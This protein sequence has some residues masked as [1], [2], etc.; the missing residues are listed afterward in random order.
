MKITYNKN[1]LYTTIDLDEHEKK[2]LWYKIKINEMEELLSCASF[3]L[4][5][6][7]YFDLER[8]RSEVDPDYYCTDEKSPLDKRCDT[9]LEHYLADLQAC[10]VG[11]CTCVACSC[12]KCQA[13]VLLGI[14]TMPGLGKHSARKIDGAFGKDNEKT[15]EE[16]IDSLANYQI[17]PEDF[18]GEAWKKLGGYE[19]YV[20][21][22]TAE[23]KHAHDWLV[24]YKNE[25]FN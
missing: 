9:L 1:P 4:G 21:R 11:D 7:K 14:D 24:K 22:W 5:E 8:A 16:A 6:D 15:I 2:E 12:S 17:N 19:Q 3:Y 10:H 25:H 23:A 18:T 13:E 20:P